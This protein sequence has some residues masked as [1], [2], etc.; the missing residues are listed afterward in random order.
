MMSEALRKAAAAVV[1]RWDSP[2]WKDGTHTADYIN[3]LREALAEPK[4][5]QSEPV[6]W[7]GKAWIDEAKRGRNGTFVNQQFAGFDVPL[8]TAAPPRREPLTPKQVAEAFHTMF[9]EPDHLL[10][11]FDAGVRFAERNLGVGVKP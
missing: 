2:D 3:A 8:Y 10:V 4:Q 7:T 5:E 9:A 1:A 6:F 11:L